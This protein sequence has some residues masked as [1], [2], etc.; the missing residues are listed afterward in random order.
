GGFSETFPLAAGED[1]DFCH[2]WQHEGWETVFVPEAVVRHNHQLTLRGFGRQHFNY[3]RGLYL[4]RRLIAERERKVFRVRH[5]SFY[6]GLVAFPLA[7]GR[8]RG[9]WLYSALLVGS[10]VATL[11]GAAWEWAATRWSGTT[12]GE[13]SRR[14]KSLGQHE[15]GVTVPRGYPEDEDLKDNG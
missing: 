14:S 15:R 6:L 1:H 5:A 13:H 7:Q 11:A 4:C 2:R 8:G 12:L 3:G 9:G 10:Q